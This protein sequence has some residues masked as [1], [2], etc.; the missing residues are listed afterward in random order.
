MNYFSAKIVFFPAFQY[1]W[2][3]QYIIFWRVARQR[4]G[5]DSPAQAYANN[6]RIATARQRSCKHASLTIWTVF[7]AW[8][9]QRRYTELFGCTEQ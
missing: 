5:E 8:S 1:V 9:V 3:G 2:E 4:H 6:S 7:S